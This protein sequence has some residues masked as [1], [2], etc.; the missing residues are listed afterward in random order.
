MIDYLS[1]HPCHAKLMDYIIAPC[2][3]PDAYD[4]FVRSKEESKD[5]CNLK[6]S[7][8]KG[9]VKQKPCQPCS[10]SKSKNGT[11]IMDLTLNF[12]VILGADDLRNIPTE[13]FLGELAMLPVLKLRGL[14]EYFFKKPSI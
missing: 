6:R 9:A 1:K 14:L 11:V 2:G 7:P 4:Q 8:S 5:P 10:G 3:N 13:N 12:P